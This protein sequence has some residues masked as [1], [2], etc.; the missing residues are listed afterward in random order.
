MIK[1]Y[2]GPLARGR[3]TLRQLWR[4]AI[5]RWMSWRSRVDT[6]GEAACAAQL[7]AAEPSLRWRAA[8]SLGRNPLREPEA[9]Q[10]LIHAL[11]DP[12]P[13]VRWQA[14][15]A[16]AR[17]EP[18]RVFSA[19]VAALAD[20]E[21]LRRAGAAE[22]LGGV[23]GEAAVLA[24]RPHLQDPVPQVR[25]AVAAALGRLADPT[26]VPDLFPL[27]N[28]GDPDVIRAAAA[29]LGK[30]G[31]TSAA[32]P[33]ARA[34]V[35]PGQPVLVRR[36]LAAALAH[37]PHPDVQLQLLAALSDPDPQVRAYVAQA[38]GQVGDEGAH[39][40]LRILRS[41]RSRLLRD[42]VGDWAGRALALLERRGRRGYPTEHPGGKK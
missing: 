33:L 5:Q 24:L 21:P 38:L 11:A 36:A 17:Q 18:G 12:E 28:D 22:A 37:V 13:I 30:L 7:A 15:E 19:L 41:D 39:G 40:P 2:G 20:E 8:E 29:A 27:L 1:N 42:T 25:A 35:K 3:K 32:V 34:L 6:A 10:A 4:R 23:R 31:S 16:L 9:I 26:V 14:A